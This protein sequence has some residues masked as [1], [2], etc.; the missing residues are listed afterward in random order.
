MSVTGID[1]GNKLSKVAG[2]KNGSIEILL[3]NQSNRMVPSILTS[4]DRRYT[5]HEAKNFIKNNLNKSIGDIKELIFSKYNNYKLNSLYFNEINENDMIILDD[6]QYFL[7]HII[8]FLFSNFLLNSLG[9]LPNELVVSVPVAFGINEIEFV[10]NSLSLLKTCDPSIVKEDIA[11]GLD[12]GYYRAIQKKFEEPENILFINVGEVTTHVF[13]IEFSN[14]QMVIK[15]S[16]CKM[17]LGGKSFDE[18]LSKYFA[19]KIKEKYNLDFLSNK[20]MKYTLLQEAEKVKKMLSTIE[21]AELN[22]DYSAEDLLI[23]ESIDLETFNKITFNLIQQL[24]YLIENCLLNFDQKISKVEMLGGGMRCSRIKDSISNLLKKELSYSLNAEESIA[25]GCVL[26]GALNSLSV[27][28]NEY[29]CNRLSSNICKLTIGDK[30]VVINNEPIN[31]PVTKLITLKKIK[32]F[33][34]KIKIYLNNQ[35]KIEEEILENI[36]EDNK[37]QIKLEI[38]INEIVRIKEIKEITQNNENKI[39][40]LKN[41][42]KFESI[43]NQ[44]MELENKL[45]YEEN[46][47]NHLDF[48]K[49][50]IEEKFY[51]L[52]EKLEYDDDYKKYL[53][54]IEIQNLRKTLEKSNEFFEEEDDTSKIQEYENNLS[55]LKLNITEVSFRKECNIQIPLTFNKISKKLEEL[56]EKLNSEINLKNE[57]MIKLKDDV[58]E[59]FKIKSYQIKEYKL[60]ESPIFTSQNLD[61]EFNKFEKQY[62]ELIPQGTGKGEN[63]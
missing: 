59:W 36:D 25:K 31:L 38:D 41:N 10:N 50:E 24:E 26:Y 3:F 44:I 56:N 52:N 8:G 32:N 20:K 49:N 23:K 14:D 30:E 60:N 27:K 19:K 54:E 1:F 51:F 57:D 22:I 5:G 2:L 17:G 28:I 21:K 12:Y 11:I 48:V 46:L 55:N 33:N 47:L 15:N 58:N 45:S 43:H 61:E 39:F 4:L 35:I 6:K 42:N 53:S 18:I 29:K 37:V 9:R 40:R 16:V 62:H 13:L 7:Q 63:M 34:N